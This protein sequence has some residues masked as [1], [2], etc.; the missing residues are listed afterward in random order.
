MKQIRLIGLISSIVLIINYLIIGPTISFISEAN[1]FDTLTWINKTFIFPIAFIGFYVALYKLV[2][3]FE[4]KKLTVPVLIIL[5]LGF[6][7]LILNLIRFSGINTPDILNGLP[8][9]VIMLI[10]IIWAIQVI[11]N[12]DARFK[13]IRLFA[14][15]MLVGYALVFIFTLINMFA[16]TLLYESGY[17]PFE[18]INIAYAIYGVGYV[19]GLLIFVEKFKPNIQNL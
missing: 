4:I 1:W 9:I 8:G 6:I 19:F 10:F 3:K 5:G 18:Y 11:R 12:K 14:L 17:Q 13:R 7:S 2:H 16:I 15:A